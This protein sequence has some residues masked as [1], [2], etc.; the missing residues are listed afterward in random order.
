VTRCTGFPPGAWRESA[1]LRLTSTQRLGAF[2]CN[3]I[4]RF[5]PGLTRGEPNKETSMHYLATALVLPGR[6]KTHSLGEN[7][8]SKRTN[9]V[10]KHFFD[11]GKDTFSQKAKQV[12]RRMFIY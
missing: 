8:Y 1:F 4:A 9:S 2:L 7:Y 12:F 10:E 6:C 5:D 11:Y 3:G